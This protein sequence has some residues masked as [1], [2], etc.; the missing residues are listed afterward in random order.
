[1]LN[2]NNFKMLYECSLLNIEN[3]KLTSL[4]KYNNKIKFNLKNLKKF[5]LDFTYN[6]EEEEDMSEEYAEE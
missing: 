6:F 4:I 2:F 3:K 5:E 1:M